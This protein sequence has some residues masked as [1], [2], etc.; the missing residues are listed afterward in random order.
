MTF[1]DTLGPRTQR[2]WNAIRQLL[3]DGHWHTHPELV[4]AATL[5]SDITPKSIDELIRKGCRTRHYTRRT[6]PGRGGRA[7]SAVY[8]IVP[9][10][11]A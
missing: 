5:A 7:Q 4:E 3:A 9:K 10:D 11:G 1:P 2:A 8:R 6:F